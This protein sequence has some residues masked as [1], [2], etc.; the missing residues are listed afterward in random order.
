MTLR[1]RALPCPNPRVVLFDSKR[2]L[3]KVVFSA[4]E[5]RTK[6]V[7]RC[8][9]Y[10]ASLTRAH[11]LEARRFSCFCL[12]RCR[13]APFTLCQPISVVGCPGLFGSVRRSSRDVR[14]SSHTPRCCG[15]QGAAGNRVWC[16]CPAFDVVFCF[17]GR[18]FLP[19]FFFSVAAL[20]SQS[21]CAVP[22]P[23]GR[24]LLLL[25]LP[26]THLPLRT[27]VAR[28]RQH[29]RTEDAPLSS[30]SRPLCPPQLPF[31][32]LSSPLLSC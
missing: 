13:G 10:L 12:R 32:L 31:R 23:R 24:L 9:L 14:V 8:L 26:P 11:G 19:Q 18:S 3:R 25:L 21:V 6:R 5:E 22:R 20:C 15:C 28:V 30:P 29:Q 16:L 1:H 27:R 7:G 4:R 17:L 2:N